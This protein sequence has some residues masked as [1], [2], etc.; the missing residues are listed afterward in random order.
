MELVLPGHE[1]NDFVLMVLIRSKKMLWPALSPGKMIEYVIY[2]NYG[3]GFSQQATVIACLIGGRI[4]K[5]AVERQVASNVH[6]H[7]CDLREVQLKN[8]HAGLFSGGQ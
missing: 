5:F 4:G 7:V 6:V 8:S 3:D 2:L 1:E